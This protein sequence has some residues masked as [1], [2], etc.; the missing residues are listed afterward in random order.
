MAVPFWST[1]V[2]T[3]EPWSITLTSPPKLPASDLQGGIGTPVL[4]FGRT[5]DL[6]KSAHFPLLQPPAADILVGVGETS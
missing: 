4:L 2:E 6:C 3:V 5:P 1:R